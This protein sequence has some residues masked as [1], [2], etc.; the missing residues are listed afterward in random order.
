MVSRTRLALLA[1]VLGVASAGCSAPER[2]LSLGFKEVPSDVVLGDQTRDTSAP[3][4]SPVAPA[5]RP[6]P[7]SIVALPPPPFE[8]RRRP[9]PPPPVAAACPDTDP[10]RA[11]AVEAPAH[12]AAPPVDAQY[13]FRNKGTFEVSGANA[14]RGNF[15]A[16]SLRTV[17]VLSQDEDGRVFDFTVA[18]TLA[19]I[20]TTTT[21]RVVRTGELSAAPGGTSDAGLYI[22]QIESRRPGGEAAL[23]TPTPELKLAAL[24]LVRGAR[25]EARGVDPTTA[26]TM[27]FVSTVAGKARVAA[28]G[29]PL[30]SFTLELTEGTVLSPDQDLEFAATYA[31]GTQFGGLFLQETVAFAGTDGDAG[32][33][34]SNTAT[35]SQT[36]RR[37]DES[38]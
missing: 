19:D 7:P 35:I 14:Q 8:I 25:V 29:E 15:P 27:S 5:A 23:F 28:C 12:I 32:V 2:P 34:R 24:P 16:T 6:L 3:S 1:L 22:R 18:E 26:T 36:P 30:D 11:P 21:Y 10:L 4:T 20:T 13:L 38:R 9:P 31:V 33:S 37:N 17:K